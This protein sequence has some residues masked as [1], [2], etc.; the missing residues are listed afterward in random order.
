MKESFTRDSLGVSLVKFFFAAILLCVVIGPFVVTWEP[1]PIERYFFPENYWEKRATALE[2]EIKVEDVLL[3][4]ARIELDKRLMVAES[5]LEETI[6]LNTGLEPY[7][8]IAKKRVEARKQDLID[9]IRRLK[10]KVARCQWKLEE[11]RRLLRQAR[12]EL[13]KFRQQAK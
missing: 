11:D 2:R 10:D 3:K 7:P 9:E 1:G 4:D 13:A 6:E 8:S 5:D 12:V